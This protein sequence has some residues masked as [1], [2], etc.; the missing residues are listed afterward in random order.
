MSYTC[1][2]VF[3]WT[4][5][6]TKPSFIWRNKCN[7][8]GSSKQ[9]SITSNILIMRVLNFYSWKLFSKWRPRIKPV[10]NLYRH[11]YQLCHVLSRLVLSLGLKSFFLASSTVFFN[12]KFLRARCLNSG[13]LFGERVK[14]KL[15]W[16]INSFASQG[17]WSLMLAFL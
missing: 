10:L 4:M 16:G 12:N 1:A 17:R 11:M 7:T 15:S 6:A 2:E 3:W 5:V 14:V 13:H 8:Q 9:L